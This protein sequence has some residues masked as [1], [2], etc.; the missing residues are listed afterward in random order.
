MQ[1]P[2]SPVPNDVP[3][4]GR[5]VWL[6]GDDF[7]KLLPET[8]IDHLLTQEE[9]RNVEQERREFEAVG[10]AMFMT[11][12]N[13]YPL[14]Y[15]AARERIA[16]GVSPDE[17]RAEMVALEEGPDLPWISIVREAYDD[18]L[19]GRPPRFSSFW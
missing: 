7:D 15:D 17:I 3:S 12:E 19:A 1:T 8:T 9:R 16:S 11:R 10:K 6:D 14:F 4:G 18:L 5:I 13:V 2:E